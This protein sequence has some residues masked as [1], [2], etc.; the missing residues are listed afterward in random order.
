[1]G[2]FHSIAIAP[3]PPTGDWG[4]KRGVPPS[5]KTGGGAVPPP[6]LPPGPLLMTF[7]RR[8]TGKAGISGPCQTGGGTPYLPPMQVGG[9]PPP[10][11]KDGG[12]V[13]PPTPRLN[14]E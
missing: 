12:G 2:N 13:V 9:R 14:Y 4:R 5:Q 3:R 1:M 8:K 6:P 10:E 11:K 7:S